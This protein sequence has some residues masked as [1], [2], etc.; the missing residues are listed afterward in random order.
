[1]VEAVPS[2]KKCGICG[3][4]APSLCSRCKQVGYC[5]V[6]HQRQ[7]WSTHKKIC[8]KQTASPAVS[9]KSHAPAVTDSASAAGAL[10]SSAGMIDQDNLQSNESVGTFRWN[11]SIVLKPAPE[12]KIEQ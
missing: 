8:G 5:G 4:A 1:M 12:W 2:T 10:L 3:K 6:E 7:D 9:A 11:D